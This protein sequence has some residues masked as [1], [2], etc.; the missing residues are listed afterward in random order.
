MGTVSVDIMVK[1]NDDETVLVGPTNFF[2]NKMI[3]SIEVYTASPYD[4][5]YS[6]VRSGMPHPNER[7]AFE[8]TPNRHTFKHSD[9]VHTV[10]FQKPGSFNDKLQRFVEPSIFATI[11]YM[12]GYRTTIRKSLGNPLPLRTTEYRPEKIEKGPMFYQERINRTGYTDAH[13]ANL[14][15]AIKIKPTGTG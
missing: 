1:E 13:T 9:R 4:R 15:A 7:A 11:V 6:Y 10:V 14:A 5:G 2:G 3:H 12:T 8:N